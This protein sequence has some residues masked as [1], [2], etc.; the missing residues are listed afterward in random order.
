MNVLLLGLYETDSITNKRK[1]L[2]YQQ[3]LFLVP[4]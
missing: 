1:H 3:L 4:K 2:R